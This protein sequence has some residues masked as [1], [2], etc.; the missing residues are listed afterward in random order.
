MRLREEDVVFGEDVWP[1]R[2]DTL[3]ACFDCP[4]EGLDGL[5]NLVGLEF[6]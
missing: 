4:L 3:T 2:H 6:E 5:Y 1:G